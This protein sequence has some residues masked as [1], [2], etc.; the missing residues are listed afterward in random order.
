MKTLN[1]WCSKL[2]L[3]GFGL[4]FV[5]SVSLLST[6]SFATGLTTANLLPNPGFETWS[7]GLPTNWSKNG[8]STTLTKA[9][10]HHSGSYAAKIATSS[11][12]SVASGLND[13]TTPTITS[14]I[15][16]VTYTAQCWALASTTLSVKIQLHE[17]T[18]SGSSVNAAVSTTT[19]VGTAW[20]K[21]TAVSFKATRNGDRLPLSISASLVKGGTTYTVDDCSLTEKDTT[22]PSTPAS[23]T[24]SGVSATQVTLGWSAA[25]DNVGVSGYKISRNGTQLATTASTTFSDT[26]AVANTAYTYSVAAYDDA[27]NTGTA[28]TLNVTTPPAAPTNLTATSPAQQAVLNWNAVSGVNSYNIY[29]DGSQ[30]ASSTSPTYTDSSAPSGNH[31]YTVTAVGSS[32]SQPSASVNV[33]VDTVA[34]VITATVSPTPQTGSWN[35][36]AVTITYACSD[37]LSGIAV[38][39]G[40][41]TISGEGANQQFTATATDKAGNSSSTTTTVNLDETAPTLGTPTWSAN[42]IIVGSSTTLTVPVSD[43]L[44]GVGG[45]EYYLGST[46]PG[47][48]KGTA[49]TYASGSLTATFGASLTPGTYTVNVRSLDAA[50]NWSPVTTSTLT[51]ADQPPSTPTNL[52]AYTTNPHQINLSWTASTPGNGTLAGYQI[53]RS[54][55]GGNPAVI[56]TVTGTTYNDTSLAAG[57]T[58]SYTVAAVDNYGVTSAASNSAGDN[59]PPNTS[60]LYSTTDWAKAVGAVIHADNTQSVTLPNGN[61]LWVFDDTTQVNGKSTVG[62]FGY[63]HDVFVSQ[64]PG[65]LNFTALAGPYGYGWQQIPNWSDGTYFWPSNL[66][67]DNGTLYIFGSRVQNTSTGGFAVVG[68]YVAEF[69]PTTLAYQNIVQVPAGATGQTVW[70]GMTTVSTGA[71]NGWMVTGSHGVTC[72]FATNCKVGDFAYIPF[73]AIGNPSA[74]TVYDNVIPATDNLGTT[75]GIVPTSTGWTLFTK[76]GDAYGGSSIESLTSSTITNGG[77]WTLTGTTWSIPVPSG[78]VSYGA[79]VH[80]E[81]SAPSGQILVSYNVNGSDN[82]AYPAPQFLYLTP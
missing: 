48:G 82:S 60:T 15:S 5:T 3:S 57:G 46:D 22:A 74:W 19:S 18:A 26:T 70:G 23:L 27:G 30:L 4:L 50:G 39:P 47:Q 62:A 43:A 73:G 55:N 81:Q 45:G 7:S 36:T 37:S 13:G 41:L 76:R 53:S 14:T 28:A 59:T 67:V 69:N 6:P 56:A 8:S 1:G 9:T 42:P 52:T 63:P 61:I 80:V 49:M 21:L 51:V 24:T 17:T 79:A 29:R 72:S 32:E 68:Q 40:P 2:V 31:T 11:T 12:S 58:Y 77:S 35:N 78:A 54:S 16:G 33:L 64:T 66:A 44:S 20:T 71:Y 34:P 75:L 25:T 38:C 10:T 65:T